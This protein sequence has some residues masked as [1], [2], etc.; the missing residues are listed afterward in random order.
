MCWQMFLRGAKFPNA[1]M[2]VERA[3]DLKVSSLPGT[4]F[5]RSCDQRDFIDPYRLR[6]DALLE[7]GAL[8]TAL[9]AHISSE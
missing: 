9:E 3:L 2:P 7:S 6:N 4:S 5:A 1:A 8:F